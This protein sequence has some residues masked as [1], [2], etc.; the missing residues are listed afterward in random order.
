M[1][2][3]DGGQVVAFDHVAEHGQ[4]VHL[5][6]QVEAGGGLV[7]EQEFRFLDQCAGDGDLLE[8]AAAELVDVAQGE[9]VEV[10]P[11][12]GRIDHAQVLFAHPPDDVRLAAHEHRVEN[13]QP[14]GLG[15]LG[16]VADAERDLGGAHREHVAVLDQDLALGGRVDGVYALEQGGLAHAV[17]AEDGQQLAAV[18]VELHGVEHGIAVVAEIEAGDRED[19]LRCPLIIR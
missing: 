8:F 5:A 18:Q 19:H 4:D 9:V 13:G 16:H 14:G 17:G 12:Q 1:H 7:Q 15:P 11:F 6:A 10:Q 2:G 3:H